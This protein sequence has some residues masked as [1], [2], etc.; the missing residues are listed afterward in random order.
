MSLNVCTCQVR[1]TQATTSFCD[2]ESW[3][4][5]SLSHKY[6]MHDVGCAQQWLSNCDVMFVNF[7]QHLLPSAFA[8]AN[9]DGMAESA[10]SKHDNCMMNML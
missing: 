3:R 9:V 7:L 10:V 6:D 2:T 1:M 4:F 8:H 5:K